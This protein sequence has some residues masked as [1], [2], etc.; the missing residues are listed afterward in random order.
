MDM[1]GELLPALLG[2]YDRPT[3]QPIN[4]PTERGAHR[5]IILSIR[6]NTSMKL[7]VIIM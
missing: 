7:D 3:D 2:N 6:C 5:N 1:I 4:Q